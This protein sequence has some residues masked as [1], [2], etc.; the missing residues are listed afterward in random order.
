MSVKIIAIGFVLLFACAF[1]FYRKIGC[2]A[3]HRVQIAVIVVG[4]GGGYFVKFG[5]NKTFRRKYHTL[6]VQ[7]TAYLQRKIA[8]DSLFLVARAMLGIR[9]KFDLFFQLGMAVLY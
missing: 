9:T 7:H 8:K 4:G 3:R 5:G 2:L 1:A 6:V